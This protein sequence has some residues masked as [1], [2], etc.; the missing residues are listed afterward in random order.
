MAN[1]L[2][3]WGKEKLL[4][5]GVDWDTDTIRIQLVLGSPGSPL[6][7]NLDDIPAG[8]RTGSPVALTGKS[9]TNGV[10][11]A[12]DPVVTAVPTPG[13]GSP[14]NQVIIYKDSGVESTSTVIAVIDTATGLPVTAN[15]G[16][17][18]VVWDS[19]ASK[20]FAL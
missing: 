11:D 19:G 18:S 10:A 8:L 2:T 17:I 5:A 15:G 3:N 16:D 1:I 13:G 6:V 9:I 7:Q 14:V 12:A 20:I 4:D